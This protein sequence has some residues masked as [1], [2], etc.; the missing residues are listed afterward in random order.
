VAIN[1]RRAELRAVRP[2]SRAVVNDALTRAA[3]FRAGVSACKQLSGK[4]AAGSAEA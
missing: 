3:R 2:K 4:I 1:D